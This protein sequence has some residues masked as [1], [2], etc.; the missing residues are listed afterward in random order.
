MKVDLYN[1]RLHKENTSSSTLPFVHIPLLVRFKGEIS[2]CRHIIPIGY[3]NKS[4]IKNGTQCERMV[5]QREEMGAKRGCFFATEDGS[6][7]KASELEDYLFKVL[8]QVQKQTVHITKDVNVR[9]KCDIYRSVRRGSTTHAINM[10][11]SGD[12]VNHNNRWRKVEPAGNIRAI[13]SMIDH[14]TQVKQ[15][16][17]ALMRYLQAL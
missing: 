9:E 6:R 11:V 15:A 7:M 12:E 2:T 8:E 3:K 4:G 13:F 14:Y 5:I 17:T 1:L 16:I 10:N